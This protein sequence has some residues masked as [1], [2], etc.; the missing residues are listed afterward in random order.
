MKKRTASVMATALLLSVA[1]G[2]SAN[3]FNGFYVGAELG[4]QST[5]GREEVSDR[6]SLD[7]S[8]LDGFLTIDT[9]LTEADCHANRKNSLAG[10]IFAGYGYSCDS[11]FIGAEVF[12]RASHYKTT[13]K[14]YNSFSFDL[15]IPS[16]GDQH[17]LLSTPNVL[18]RTTYTKLNPWDFGLDIRP[19]FL[20]SCD[21]L[22]YGKIGVGFNK[23]KL[24]QCSSGDIT[25]NVVGTAFDLANASNQICASKKRGVLR[26]GGG[27]EQR[28]C[29]C[30]A[31][32]L[33][34]TYSHYGKV[35]ASGET[36]KNLLSVDELIQA[37]FTVGDTASVKVT[38]NTLMAGLSYYW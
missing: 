10:G 1:T 20:L 19:G 9:P 11:W 29:E 24:Q 27:L 32:R 7:V 8:I 34:Y 38:S 21:S 13:T 15:D 16:L 33:D 6:Q 30:F 35:C 14:G 5:T 2:A 4:G 26:L 17:P 31:L 3:A 28:F 25:L 36:T 12:A 37:N 18:T 22:V 23:L